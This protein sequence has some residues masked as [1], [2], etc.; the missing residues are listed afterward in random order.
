MYHKIITEHAFGVLPVSEETGDSPHHSKALPFASYSSM[1]AFLLLPVLRGD[2]SMLRLILDHLEHDP[3]TLL[4]LSSPLSPSVTR[5]RA[6]RKTH[7]RST[8][9]LSLSRPLLLVHPTNT[10]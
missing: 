4:W 9:A 3:V 8:P 7:S 6:Q 5:R 2:S 10:N 1:T